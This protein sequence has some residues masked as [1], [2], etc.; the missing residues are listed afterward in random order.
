VHEL[1]QPGAQ[2]VLGRAAEPNDPTT[3]AAKRVFAIGDAMNLQR[4]A[5]DLAGATGVPIEALDLALLNWS[6]PEDDRITA[7]AGPVDDGPLR[8]R[9]R[10]AP[11]A[12]PP[13][14]G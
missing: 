2:Q 13:G 14:E 1:G 4:R 7:G 8:E 11:R 5:A 12:T 3:V 6:R 10:L 9:L